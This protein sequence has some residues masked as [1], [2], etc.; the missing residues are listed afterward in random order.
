MPTVYR[1]RMTETRVTLVPKPEV[2][3]A[4]TLDATETV[5]RTAAWSDV[6]ARVVA[7]EATD[8]GVRL[9]LPSDPTLVARVAELTVREADCCAFFGF[10]ITVEHEAVWLDV[11]APPDGLAVVAQLFGRA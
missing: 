2:P 8:T 9:Q 6:L 7:R 10:A 4:C 3:I 11:A 5:D 1:L